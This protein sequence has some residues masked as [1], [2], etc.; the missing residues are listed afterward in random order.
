MPY[1]SHM[2]RLTFTTRRDMLRQT[3]GGFGSLA[4]TALLNKSAAAIGPS[5]IKSPLTARSP[6]FAPRAKNVIFLFMDGGVSH[7]DTFDPKPKLTNENGRPFTVHIEPTQFDKIGN[8]L[9][10]PWTFDKYGESGIPVSQL[11]PHVAQCVDDICVIRSMTAPS[12]VHQNADYFLHSG[13]TI[14]GRP[15]MGAWIGYGL[16]TENHNLPAFVVLYGGRLPPGGFDCFTSGFLPAS[17]RGTIFKPGEET[18]AN[19]KSLEKFPETQR[20]KFDLMRKLDQG[21]LQR[22]GPI[23]ALESTIANYEVAARMQTAVPE[24]SDIRDE[25]QA[26]RKLYALDDEDEHTRTYGLECL[27]ARRMVERGVRFVEI[28]G[29]KVHGINRWD[30]HKDLVKNHGTN[31]HIVDQP[32]AALLR[33]LKSRGLLESTIVVWAG[34]FGR[35][36]FAEGSGVGRDHSPFGFTTW[37]AGGGFR[38]G[39]IYG[40]TDEFGYHAVENPL[41]IYDLHATILHQLGIDH[42]QLTYRYGGRDMRLTDVHGNVIREIIA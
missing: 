5:G 32:I 41:E 25:S 29:P 11:F 20:S 39:S 21:T 12:S 8:T 24:L 33:D 26:T 34:E 22:L 40:A 18:I 38:G 31:A 16:G 35:T 30:A 19:I 14:Q 13:F 3:A 10:S 1:Q 28:L 6:Q 4:L 27:L 37:V 42:T 9:G 36:P 7:I 15:S 2:N 17:Y 23:D